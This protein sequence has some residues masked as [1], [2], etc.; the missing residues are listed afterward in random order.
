MSDIQ[1]SPDWWLASDS[2]WYPPES[3]R[4]QLAPPPPTPGEPQAPKFAIAYAPPGPGLS[5]ALTG[6]LMA[7]FGLSAASAAAVSATNFLALKEF[8]G[9]RTFGSGQSQAEWIHM[10]H[11]AYELYRVFISVWIVTFVVL[12]LWMYRAHKASQL[13]WT[14]QRRWRV[15]WTLGGWCIPL[16]QFVIP[17]LVLNEIEQIAKAPRSA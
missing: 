5:S 9:F 3:R 10:A 11:V 2:K 12:V 8:K 1:Q 15:G 17:K 6:W 14:G 4:A 13:L 16:A 7:L